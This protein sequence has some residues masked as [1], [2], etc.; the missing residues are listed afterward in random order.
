MIPYVS[1]IFDTLTEILLL[2]FQYIKRNTN[3][4]FSIIIV[5]HF[6]TYLLC[7]SFYRYMMPLIIIESHG[8]LFILRYLSN[9]GV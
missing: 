5:E 7:D 1:N 9:S 4:H 2:F 8:F 3:Y 6:P